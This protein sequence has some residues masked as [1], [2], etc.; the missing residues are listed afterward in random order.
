MADKHKQGGPSQGRKDEPTADRDHQNAGS[1]D[2]LTNR[3]A[4]NRRE[5]QSGFHPGG[6]QRTGS[7][8]NR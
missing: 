2:E 4:D 7:D 5:G 6:G 3:T 1:H 8:K